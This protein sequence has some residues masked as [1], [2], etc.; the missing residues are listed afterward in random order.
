M[1][2]DLNVGGAR[3]IPADERKARVLAEVAR[4]KALR[5]Q[6][7]TRRDGQARGVLGS[8]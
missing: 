3:D 7:P 5:S 1:H 8:E 4:L 6:R 2:L